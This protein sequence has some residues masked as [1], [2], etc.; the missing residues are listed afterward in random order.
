MYETGFHFDILLI[1]FIYGLAFFAMGLA[2]AL[3]I[4]RFPSLVNVN[5]LVPLAGF[6]ILH[7]LHEWFEVYLMQIVWLGAEFPEWIAWSRLVLLA[8]SFIVLII[9]GVGAFRLPRQK[10][11]PVAA[12]GLGILAIYILIIVFNAVAAYR[13]GQVIWLRFTDALIRYLLAVPGALLAAQGL[14]FQASAARA[15][16]R[17]PLAA[18]LQWA[19]LG[20]GIYGLTQIFVNQVDMFPARW[21]SADAFLAAT[22]VPIQAIRSVMATVVMIGML[23]ATQVLEAE[24]QKQLLAAQQ[25]RLEAL[26]QI[27]VELTKREALRRELLRHTVQAQE[28]ERARIARELHDETAQILSAFT[29]DLATLQ[30]TLPGHPDAK[31]LIERLQTH[32]RQMSQGLYHLVHDLRPAQLDDLGLVP[33]LN[34]LLERDFSPKGLNVSLEVQGE[35][36]RLDP[37][38]ETVF[39]RVAQEAVTNVARHAKTKKALIQLVYAPQ[40]ITLRVIDSGIGFDPTETFNPPRGWGLAGMRERVESVGGK[41]R[42]QSAPGKGTTIEVVVPFSA[43]LVPSG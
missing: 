7:G 18:S 15:E 37:I 41:L 12:L 35:A 43:W 29:L 16:N 23:R 5:L 13:V 11:L 24:R 20:F 32:S 9:Y 3:E 33:T 21:I 22:G 1:F 10:A 26:E 40:Q 14:H 2:M 42:I 38:L 30:S 36:R 34:Y 4:G 19:A 27:Q 17:R 39:F 6:G 28:D 8:I 31:L 25:A